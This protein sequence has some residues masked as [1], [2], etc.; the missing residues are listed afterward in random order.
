MT[1]TPAGLGALGSLLTDSTEAPI[2]ASPI[3]AEREGRDD[4]VIDMGAAPLE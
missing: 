2:G 3:E 4:S 1:S